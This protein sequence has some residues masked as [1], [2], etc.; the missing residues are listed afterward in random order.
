MKSGS[1]PG[2]TSIRGTLGI[3]GG[4]G[5]AGAGPSG[6][7]NTED[8][9][10]S[11]EGIGIA[12]LDAGPSGRENTEDAGAGPGSTSAVEGAGAGPGSTSAVEGA[13]GAGRGGVEGAVE[14]AAFSPE[15]RDPAERRER[16]RERLPLLPLGEP[17]IVN[18]KQSQQS[19][20][21]ERG[22]TTLNT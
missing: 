21:E 17:A 3:G 6:R 12:A 4:I 20:R 18:S 13:G 10:A 9:G 16:L 11:P 1:G 5:I 14:G 22:G 8:A 2:R 19:K 15:R 7:E